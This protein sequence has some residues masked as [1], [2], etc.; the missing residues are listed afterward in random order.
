MVLIDDDFVSNEEKKSEFGVKQ[1]SC[2]DIL[3]CM[4]RILWGVCFTY[5]YNLW[6]PL[7]ILVVLFICKVVSLVVI[8]VSSNVTAEYIDDYSKHEIAI[9]KINI[10]NN[11]QHF[12]LL[13]YP[14]FFNSSLV[15]ML[16][17][18]FVFM[19]QKR[20]IQL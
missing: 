8:K 20:N 7:M 4:M 19:H 12:T 15:S 5:I 2:Q 9:Q 17:L 16:L 6:L 14:I 1:Y 18:Y 11:T 3:F 10:L 13:F